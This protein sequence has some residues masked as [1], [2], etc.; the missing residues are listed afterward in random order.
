M[1]VRFMNICISFLNKQNRSLPKCFWSGGLENRSIFLMAGSWHCSDYWELG[2]VCSVQVRFGSSDIVLVSENS[3]SHNWNGV[4]WGSVITSHI[5]V[6]LADCSV[7]GDI[8]VFLIHIMDSSSGLI[9]EDNSKGLDMIRSSFID[10]IHW[11][12]LSLGCFSF[13]LSS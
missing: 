12:N 10:F 7:E 6:E 3:C 4:S 9:P 5:H 1:I 13:E 11:K 8:S 2:V